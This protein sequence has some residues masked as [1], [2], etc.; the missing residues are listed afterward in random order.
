MKTLAL[1]LFCKNEN[2]YLKEWLDYHFSIGVEHIFLYDN[3]SDIQLKK[4]V[5]PYINDGLVT[6][7]RVKDDRPGRQCRVYV[8]CIKTHGRKFKWIGFID[9][10]EFIVIKEGGDLKEFLKPYEKHAALGIYWKC[11]GSNGHMTPRKSQILAYTKRS[12]DNFHANAHIKSIVQPSR[13]KQKVCSDPHRFY[14]LDAYYAVDENLKKIPGAKG[15]HT[16]NKIQLNHYVLRSEEEFKNKIARGG[17]NSGEKGRKGMN[18][19]T[20]YNTVCNKVDDTIL[21]D[22]WRKTLEEKKKDGN[23]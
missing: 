19:F 3:M 2:M 18:F 15:P 22:Q 1:C 13:V 5:Q 4:T 14:Y 20:S 17:G 21:S 9:T 6:V 10:D 12:S 11:F 16:S 7:E 23:S 8:N